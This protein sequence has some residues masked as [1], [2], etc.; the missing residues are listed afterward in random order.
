[1]EISEE[2]IGMLNMSGS[3]NKQFCFILETEWVL[4]FT[5]YLV[6][7][8][9]TIKDNFSLIKYILV[10][11]CCIFQFV[12]KE[13]FFSSLSLS[14]VCLSRINWFSALNLSCVSVLCLWLPHQSKL[15]E[16]TFNTKSSDN[17]VT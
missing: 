3:W 5:R 4:T 16:L 13:M 8:F 17:E 14:S 1:M 2:Y 9:C 10:L 11:T 6:L 15:I 12:I 7:I